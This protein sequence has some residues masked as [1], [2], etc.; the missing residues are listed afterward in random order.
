MSYKLNNQYL[1]DSEYRSVYWCNKTP[2]Y[3]YKKEG[4]DIFLENCISTYE[5]R[6]DVVR[7]I[8][9]E[10]PNNSFQQDVKKER[11][12][13]CREQCIKTQK[14]TRKRR[15]EKKT[16]TEK[17]IEKLKSQNEK[18]KE[19][20]QRQKDNFKEKLKTTISK[21][22][23]KNK[24][25]FEIHEEAYKK[26]VPIAKKAHEIYQSNGGFTAKQL[27]ELYIKENGTIN[28]YNLER[29]DANYDISAAIRGIMEE[30]S[31]SSTQHWFRYGQQKSAEEVAPWLFVNKQLAIVNNLYEWKK[32]T[33]EIAKAR[34][35][36][37]RQNNGKWIYMVEGG[38][39]RFDWSE[40]KYGPLPTK[41]I[42]EKAAVDRKKGA[43]RRKLDEL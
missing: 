16:P 30:T 6:K 2:F 19:E 34:S 38:N 26:L 10:E 41:E 42:L 11:E 1:I 22:R 21:Q 17:E 32:T 37:R 25:R 31:P 40:E 18:L 28:P 24:I 4:E 3:F 35:E 9:T 33:S 12:E 43:R 29:V 15:A 7:T 5:S 13:H 36:A 23:Q 20:N 27:T 8:N 39:A 14:G